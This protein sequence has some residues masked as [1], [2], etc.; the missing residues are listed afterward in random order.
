MNVT[1]SAQI[2][3]TKATILKGSIMNIKF[4]R[5]LILIASISLISMTKSM[6]SDESE[7]FRVRANPIM[8][9]PYIDYPNIEINEDIILVGLEDANQTSSGKPIPS[10]LLGILRQYCPNFLD[11]NR[12]PSNDDSISYSIAGGDDY[13]TISISVSK[14]T[15]S[16]TFLGIKRQTSGPN[17]NL[18]SVELDEN[19]A[20]TYWHECDAYQLWLDQHSKNSE[21]KEIQ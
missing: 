11:I 10:H 18:K 14:I 19:T 1:N 5:V 16:N 15:S 13:K 3:K 9:I 8:V 12:A 6:Q 4:L 7:L 20:S 2:K 17:E 21:L